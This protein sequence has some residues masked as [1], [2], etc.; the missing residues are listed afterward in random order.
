ML[1]FSSAE[2]N[3]ASSTMDM[4]LN[5]SST[6]NSNEWNSYEYPDLALSIPG[7]ISLILLYSTSAL[8][9]LIS[10]LLALLVLLLGIRSRTPLHPFVTNLMTSNLLMAVFCIPFSFTKVMLGRWVFGEFMCPLVLFMQ[11]LSVAVTI[12]TNIAI[13]MDRS[14]NDVILRHYNDVIMG[15]IASQITSL[16]CVYS[17]VYSDTD[18]WKHQSS[19]SL[20]FV[21]VIHR[22]SMKWL[23]LSM[24]SS[25][26]PNNKKTKNIQWNPVLTRSHIKLY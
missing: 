22:W 25:V 9:S 4:T 7:Q 17:T 10:N 19:A 12:Y 13:G 8:V 20:A 15:A 5:S 26:G 3:F 1:Q 18:R 16:T 24:S 14:V 2:R 11:I 21:R 23:C 6:S